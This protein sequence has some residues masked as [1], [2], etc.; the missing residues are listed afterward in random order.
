MRTMYKQQF[1]DFNTDKESNILSRTKASKQ[2]DEFSGKVV[3]ELAD[4]S[5]SPK[6]KI[7][8]VSLYGMEF[9]DYVNNAKTK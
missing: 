4:T 2:L 3:N 5:I 1:K 7:S 9:S 8:N 6:K